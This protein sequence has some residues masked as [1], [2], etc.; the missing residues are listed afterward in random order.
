MQAFENFLVFLN[1]DNLIDSHKFSGKV[2]D[3]EGKFA[4]FFDDDTP[5]FVL[6][7]MKRRPWWKVHMGSKGFPIESKE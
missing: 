1:R 7:L 6:N 4:A 3:T 2:D 5:K